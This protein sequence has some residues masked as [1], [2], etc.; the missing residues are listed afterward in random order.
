VML[1]SIVGK[2]FHG[3]VARVLVDRGTR[4]WFI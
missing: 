3:L 1:E 4:F 2:W